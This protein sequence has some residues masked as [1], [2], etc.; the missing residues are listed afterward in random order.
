MTLSD[1]ALLLDSPQ[2]I[3]RPTQD[4][5]SSS[6]HVYNSCEEDGSLGFKTYYNVSIAWPLVTSC[7]TAPP[8]GSK[9]SEK[10]I[11]FQEAILK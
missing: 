5:A 8:T 11:P 2:Y 4:V 3:L 10:E 1:Y 9:C 6:N 7:V